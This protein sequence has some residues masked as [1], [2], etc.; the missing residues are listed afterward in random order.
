MQAL[1]VLFSVLPLLPFGAAV[2]IATE[3]PER[4]VMDF[5]SGKWQVMMYMANVLEYV[6]YGCSV[7]FMEVCLF[8]C[9]TQVQST[10]FS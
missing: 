3:V 4:F 8:P 1:D 2:Q 10:F 7:P 6:R 9:N 5:A